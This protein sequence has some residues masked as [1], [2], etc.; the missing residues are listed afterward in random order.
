[1]FV[2]DRQRA[3]EHEKTKDADT[4]GNEQQHDVI[5]ISHLL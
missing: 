4:F 1:M 5:F 3:T 2:V